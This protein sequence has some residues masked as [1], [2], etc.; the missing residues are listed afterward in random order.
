MNLICNMYSEIIVL[1]LLSHLLGANEFNIHIWV[2]HKTP[3]GQSSG[4]RKRKLYM[5][6]KSD[7]EI[8]FG[9]KS[10]TILL[11]MNYFAFILENRK[12]SR[13]FFYWKFLYQINVNGLV[14]KRHN[15]S[16]LAMELCLLAMELCLLALTHQD[17]GMD[18]SL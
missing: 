11:A 7:D 2:D 12:A 1:R 16:A 9:M 6:L 3:W 5:G 17:H 4:T 10:D 14:Q 15:S 8:T 18:K 13:E